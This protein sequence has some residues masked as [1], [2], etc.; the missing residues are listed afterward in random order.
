[1]VRSAVV[2]RIPR[3]GLHPPVLVIRPMV[4]PMPVLLGMGGVAV[5][6]RGYGE[7]GRIFGI[8]DILLLREREVDSNGDN[9]NENVCRRVS[10]DL[11]RALG[12]GM[13]TPKVAEAS[14]Q[15]GRRKPSSRADLRPALTEEYY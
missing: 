5:K 13:G 12:R 1:M 7:E 15:P 3:R 9:K 14:R 6:S 10:G 4:A 8:Q 11:R 2:P